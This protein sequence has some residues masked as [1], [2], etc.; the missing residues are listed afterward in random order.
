MSAMN[1]C[2]YYQLFPMMLLAPSVHTYGLLIPH[3]DI[4]DTQLLRRNGDFGYWDAHDT[5][6][7][8][9]ILRTKN[10]GV[11]ARTPATRFP[12]AA[13]KGKSPGKPPRSHPSALQVCGTTSPRPAGFRRRLSLQE[14]HHTWFF[15]AWAMTSAPETCSSLLSLRS[16]KVSSHIFHL[17]VRGTLAVKLTRSN[18]AKQSQEATSRQLWD[19]VL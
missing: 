17:K 12:P 14:N 5:K 7:V 15:R 19:P 16:A 1:I 10:R 2:S 18:P 3:P 11:N 8:R 6:H 4:S 9:H 13:L